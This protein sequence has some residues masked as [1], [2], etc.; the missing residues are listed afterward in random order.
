MSLKKHE[1]VKS[2]SNVLRSI[3]RRWIRHV[4][5]CAMRKGCQRS[6]DLIWIFWNRNIAAAVLCTL[7]LKRQTIATQSTKRNLSC[8]Q[9]TI[10]Y[11]LTCE[12]FLSK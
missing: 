7:L 3:C 6:L 2:E 10:L 4:C 9:V 12:L 8:V 1:T 5:V 11:I